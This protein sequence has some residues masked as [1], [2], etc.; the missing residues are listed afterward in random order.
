MWRLMTCETSRMDSP[1]PDSPRL[2]VSYGLSDGRA[3]PVLE[4]LA[5]NSHFISALSLSGPVQSRDAI[6]QA[7]RD[8]HVVVAILPPPGNRDRSNVIFEIGIA[9]GLAMPVLLVVAD[10]ENPKLPRMLQG[11]RTT[12]LD[13]PSNM[14]DAVNRAFRLG[15]IDAIPEPKATVRM[16]G[17]SRG[18][19]RDPLA[20]EY[21]DPELIDRYSALSELELIDA[22]ADLLKASGGQVLVPR[23]TSGAA[24]DQAD[25]VLWDES[26]L[27]ILGAPPLP[28][29]VVRD[30]R[31]FVGARSRLQHTMRASGANTMLVIAARG[32]G[33][34]RLSD[35]A[36]LMLGVA[37]PTLARALESQTLA[38]ALAQALNE[39][40]L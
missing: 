28:V 20:P 21:Q 11:L 14:L 8:V 32:Q 37:M 30:L 24:V 18:G 38:G 39:A 9:V 22:V 19:Q 7:M 25:L 36:S 31:S 10:A 40:E 17:H 12:S 3:E 13:R 15:S 5:E 1:N 4:V 2:F 16:R 29:E 34:R 6:R 27:P 33:S 35:G 23:A 26:L